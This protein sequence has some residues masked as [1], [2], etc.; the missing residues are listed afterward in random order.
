MAFQHK[1]AHWPS[2]I[3]EVSCSRKRQDLP[4]LAERYILDSNGSVR[5]VVGLDIKH[6][7]PNETKANS[8]EAVFSVWQPEIVQNDK[9]NPELI[10]VQKIKDQPFRDAQGNPTSSPGLSLPLSL[11]GTPNLSQAIMDHD[12]LITISTKELCEYLHEA[13]E[14]KRKVSTGLLFKKSLPAGV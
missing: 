14:W 5:A 4:K 1:D 8:K 9:G 10:A 6:Q 2:V 12:Q 3:F 13:E 11:F 7:R